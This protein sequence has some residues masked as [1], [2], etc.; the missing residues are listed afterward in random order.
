[1]DKYLGEFEIEELFNIKEIGV[2]MPVLCR[3]DNG[4]DVIAKYMRNPFGHQVLINELI[5]SGLA[6]ML[7]I[8]VPDYG[9]C[10][11]T[12]DVICGAPDIECL[13][14]DNAGPCFFSV[15]H[16]DTV[17]ITKRLVN[18]LK[19][20]EIE[21]LVLFDHIIANHDRHKGNLLIKTNMAKELFVIDHSHIFGKGSSITVDTLNRELH[22]ETI[23]TPAILKDNLQLYEL[24]FRSVGFDDGE[25]IRQAD[26]FKKMYSNNSLQKVLETIPELW[27]GSGKGD[28]LKCIVELIN[29]RIMLIDDICEMIIKE[30]RLL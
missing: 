23:L 6:D 12:E 22:K 28:I 14:N 24:L 4:M 1:M 2:T 16:G 27:I 26:K 19:P 7:G 8:N 21:S 9:I 11:L 17:P 5:G 30:R 29:K 13:D 15:Y 20:G 25:L 18:S 3:I 10:N